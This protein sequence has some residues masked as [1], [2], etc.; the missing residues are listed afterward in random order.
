MGQA[1]LDQ[2]TLDQATLGQATL[3]QATL[4][5]ATLGQ[6]T[7]DHGTVDHAALTASS[8][9]TGPSPAVTGTG[10]NVII[11]PAD[12]LAGLAGLAQG[13]GLPIYE[14]LESDWFRARGRT[15]AVRDGAR[16]GVPAWVSARVPAAGAPAD[17]PRNWTSPGDDGWRIAAAGPARRPAAPPRP[18]CRS[19]S[20]RPTWCPAWPATS[21]PA[22]R[23]WPRRP[24]SHAAGWPTSS[25]VPAGPGPRR[26][27]SRRATEPAAAMGQ[28]RRPDPACGPGRL[29][30]DRPRGGQF[31]RHE[32]RVADCL[33]QV[34]RNRT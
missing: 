22:P 32:W 33:S 34:A 31:G 11:P 30:Q 26:G 19:G 17:P 9:G 4:G 13:G 20:P 27:S 10:P 16:A 14:S 6:A 2:A 28:R 1:A 15:A 3:G 24:R 29:G 7:A 18:A 8:V 21:R 12:G 5:Q 25:A 23:P